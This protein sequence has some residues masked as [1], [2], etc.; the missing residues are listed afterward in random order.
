M[1]V[2][3]APRAGAQESIAEQLFLDGRKLM[4]EGKF[5]AACAKFKA[6]HDIDRTATGTLLN[7]ALCH[8]RI[9]RNASAWAEFRQVAAESAGKREDRVA[10]AREH[11]ARLAP[12]L[13]RVRIVVPPAARAPGLKLVLD[14][15]QA[16]AE[17]SW[18]SDLP[19]DPGP[20]VLHAS[21]PAKVAASVEMTVGD[22]AA[23]ELITV[24]VL[25]DVPVERPSGVSGVSDASD[26]A[27]ERAAAA[28]Q[29]RRIIGFS[30]SG[31]GAATLVGGLAFGLSAS[32]QNARAKSLCDPNGV[33]PDTS[34]K[35]DA[36]RTLASA[37]R[38]ATVAN[39]LSIA[40]GALFVGGT[41]VVL[42]ALPKRSTPPLALRVTPLWG[43]AGLSVGGAL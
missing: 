1:L 21:A 23:H 14:D 28:R 7:L 24:P 38:A 34:V 32:S 35:D 42:T 30:L 3:L 12:R 33:C 27:R 13:S 36:S 19:I 2:T 37:D 29:T 8:E 4:E 41:I 17:A 31:V 43:G 11:E 5:E 25:A 18:G 39:I 9:N 15:D 22:V 6:G 26:V 10:L 40:G 16:I 20:H